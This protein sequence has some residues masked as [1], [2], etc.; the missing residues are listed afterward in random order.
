ME[1]LIIT[2]SVYLLGYPLV[3]VAVAAFHKFVI[4]RKAQERILKKRLQKEPPSPIGPVWTKRLKFT[5][6]DNRDFLFAFGKNKE[7]KDNPPAIKRKLLFW[8]IW[9]TGL[10]VALSNFVFGWQAFV[11]AFVV[12]VCSFAFGVLSSKKI[13]EAREKVVSRIYSIAQS[14]LSLPAGGNPGEYVT[15]LDWRDHLKPNKVRISFPITVSDSSAEPFLRQFN[16][17]FGRETAWVPD[18]VLPTPKDP[19]NPK[20]KEDP[21]NPG[22][23]YENSVVTLKAVPPLPMRADWDEKYITNPAIA[24]SFFPVALG[25]ENGTTLT[26]EKGEKEHLLGFDLAGEQKSAAEK[27]GEVCSTHIVV[28]PM[29]LVAGG[30]GGGK[31]LDVKT[32]VAVIRKRNC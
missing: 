20:S 5:L 24:W 13:L 18:V 16:L 7:A 19:N 17:V 2:L 26:S 4:V 22:W 3:I 15:V 30:T 11:A 1:Q 21:G 10:I 31:A 32:P 23:D 6:S 29:I 12:F 14:Y 25:V 27:A 8:V 9:G 28:S